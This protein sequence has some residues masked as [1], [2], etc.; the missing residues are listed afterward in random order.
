MTPAFDSDLWAR[1]RDFSLDDPDAALPFSQR[2]ARENDWSPAFA[3]R[4]IEEY[5]RYLYLC[6]RAGH[7]CTPS[8]EV[9][10]A[11]HL[12]LC[13]TRSYWDELC[14]KVLRFP[15]HHGPT[16]GGDQEQE[17]FANWYDRTLVSYQS[18][19]GS[20]PPGN[21][22]PVTEIRFSSKP[23]FRRLD[24]SR[25][26]VLPRPSRAILTAAIVLPVSLLLYG[27]STLLASDTGDF[28]IS[29]I[30]LGVFLILL[31]IK[32]SLLGRGGGGRG[33][34]GGGGCGS[35]CGGDGCGGGGCGGD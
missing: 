8:D 1:L 32:L 13:Y 3:S 33:G 21:I 12:H 10:Q 17:K 20:P 35:S 29:M 31:V 5:K 14:G 9:D 34:W 22:W 16:A 27:C 24:L 4:V 19:F 18:A 11:W 23:R 15:L 7:P 28:P 26:L 2:L 6:A 25:H 30:I